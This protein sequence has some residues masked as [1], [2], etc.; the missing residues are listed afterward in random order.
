MS[1]Q[2]RIRLTPEEYLAI[3]RQADYKSEYYNGEVFAMA[4]ATPQHNAITANVTTELTLQLRKRPCIVF[5]SDQRIRVPTEF[6]TY[7][8]VSVVCGKPAFLNDGQLDNLLNPTLIVEV[9]SPSA[10]G[11][12]RGGKFAE[13][14]SLESLRE[15]VL[16][17]QDKHRVEH[18]V[19]QSDGNWLYGAADGP[20]ARLHLPSIDC[21]LA[22]AEVY[23]KVDFAAS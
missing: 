5:S 2:P 1:T 11:Y 22:L 13:Y 18:F 4:G 8:D 20:G 19:R 23:D 9:L 15:Y 3:E 12:D 10:E 7:A 6:Y 16:V 17:A 14:Q 21:T